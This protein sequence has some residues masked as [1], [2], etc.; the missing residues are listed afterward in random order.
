MGQSFFFFYMV[1]GVWVGCVGSTLDL[2]SWF[3]CLRW[4]YERGWVRLLRDEGKRI[5]KL[6]LPYL[7]IL[8]K[9]PIKAVT[10]TQTGT[11]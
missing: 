11:I 3:G 1:L 10:L 9:A 2:L 4:G 7:P 8:G 6:S 5:S